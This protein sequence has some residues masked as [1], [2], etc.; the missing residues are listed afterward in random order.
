MT[1][2]SD[3]VGRQL[4]WQTSEAAVSTIKDMAHMSSSVSQ[5]DI[6]VNVDAHRE[7]VW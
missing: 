5:S 7:K 6:Y 1:E 2:F 4:A 3:V